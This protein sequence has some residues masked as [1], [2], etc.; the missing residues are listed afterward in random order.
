M[1]DGVIM[2]FRICLVETHRLGDQRNNRLHKCLW[3]N[4]KQTGRRRLWPA[5]W[6]LGMDADIRKE[7]R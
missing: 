7:T 6:R 4:N 2:K 3:L 5:R 1:R